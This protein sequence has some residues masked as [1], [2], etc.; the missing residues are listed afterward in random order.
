M[1][2]FWI[3]YTIDKYFLDMNYTF[4]IIDEKQQW[5][6]FIQTQPYNVF[7]QAWNY[8]EFNEQ[9]GDS[10][11]PIGMFEGEKMIGACLTIKV[12]ARRGTFLYCPYGPFIDWNNTDLFQQFISYLKDLG[13]KEKADFIRMSPFLRDSDENRKLFQTNGFRKSPL[14]IL[15]ETTWML[16][17]SPEEDEILKNMKKDHRYLIKRA[18]RDGVV[19]KKSTDIADLKHFWP[20]YD[21]TVKRHKFVPFSRKYV[22]EEFKAFEKDGQT[23]FFMAEYEGKVLAC[24]VMYYY[25]NMGVYRHSA[26]SSDPKYRKIPASHLLQWEAIKEAKARGCKYYNF[27]GIAPPDASKPHPFYG[28]THFKMGFG[29]ER[30]DLLHCRDLPLSSKYWLNFLIES[31]RKWRRGF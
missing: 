25:G 29:G 11:F 23:V 1:T 12:K 18:E 16:D 19:I 24:S 4:R 5:D 27:W 10:K 22:E 14:H 28:I 31:W 21:E 2:S 6:E 13:K 3:R 15:A 26:S 20:L 9:M 17:V 30:Y 7:V 8:G